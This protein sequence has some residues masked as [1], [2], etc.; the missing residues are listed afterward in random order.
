MTED[1]ATI[2]VAITGITPVQRG[3]IRSL[4]TAELTLDGVPIVLH[5]MQALVEHDGRLVIRLPQYRAPDG[6]WADAIAV[7]AAVLRAIGDLYVEQTGQETK[8]KFGVAEV[9]RPAAAGGG[10]PV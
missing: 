8:Y 5:G 10:G 7:P 4:F 6:R 1:T 2:A 3:A 9:R